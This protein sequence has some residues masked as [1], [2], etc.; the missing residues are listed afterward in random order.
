MSNPFLIARKYL[1]SDANQAPSYTPLTDEQAA[2][3]DAGN[4]QAVLI[5][6]EVIGAPLWLAFRESF[7]PGD[8]IPVFYPD[9]L[10]F[11]KSKSPETLRK[12]YET[13]RAFGP[14]C[15]VRQ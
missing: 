5:D 3:I 12:I 7:D 14:G 9:D 13:K 6:S 15:K 2:E 4:V 1:E 8:G 11:L 10:Q